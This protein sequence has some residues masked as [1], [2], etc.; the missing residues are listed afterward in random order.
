MDLNVFW[1]EAAVVSAL[2]LL[3][4]MPV[5]GSHKACRLTV[6]LCLAP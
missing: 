5:R 4:L 3:S 2:S 1:R 6:A